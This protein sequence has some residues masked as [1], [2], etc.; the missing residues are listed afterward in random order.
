M[1]I[2]DPKNNGKD[3]FDMLQNHS[4]IVAVYVQRSIGAS[5]FELALDSQTYLNISIEPVS[6]D[7][8]N[9]DR[10]ALWNSSRGAIL[11]LVVSVCILIFLCLSWVI[12]YAVRRYRL[13]MSK[14]RLENRLINAAKKAVAK[15]PL[16]T[17]NETSVRDE[18]CV[19]CLDSL[20]I[21]DTVRQ[22]ACEHR[23]HQHCVD[24]WL[25]NHRHCPLCNLDILVA[26]RIS[27]PMMFTARHHRTADSSIESSRST[28]LATTTVAATA[29]MADERIHTPIPSISASIK[30]E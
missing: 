6:S 25:I 3:V 1:I 23:F 20:K 12:F 5:L 17:L 21:G 27:I 4:D 14:D 9:Y 18:S 29:P 26:Y 10:T 13:R 11:F 28:S 24:P 22:L 16:I 7:Y 19:I 8:E 15:I 2:Y 30:D